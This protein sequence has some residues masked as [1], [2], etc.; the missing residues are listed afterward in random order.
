MSTTC[1]PLITRFTAI[2]RTPRS[3]YT[4]NIVLGPIRQLP[5]KARTAGGKITMLCGR[6]G[7]PGFILL[8]TGLFAG[9]LPARR[10]AQID[11]I[12]TL[13]RANTNRQPRSVEKSR[14]PIPN[15]RRVKIRVYEVGEIGVTA[16]AVRCAAVLSSCRMVF[17]TLNVNLR[18][19]AAEIYS[20]TKYVSPTRTSC[21]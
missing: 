12:R 19:V 21:K 6:I 9:Y 8:A 17:G 2:S 5:F 7:S 13:R 3:V 1:T 14:L 15:Q 11:P 4:V 18:P 20:C 16:M 10:A